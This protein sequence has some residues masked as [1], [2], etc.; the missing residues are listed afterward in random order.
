MSEFEAMA[1]GTF[2]AF[3]A[4]VAVWYALMGYSWRAASWSFTAYLAAMITIR[5]LL[6]AT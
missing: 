5:A 6:R 3:S 4:G 1:F 2:G